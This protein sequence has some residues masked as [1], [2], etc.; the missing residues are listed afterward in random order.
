MTRR[1]RRVFTA[2]HMRTD[3]VMS[4]LTMVFGNRFPNK[5]LMQHSDRG[6]QYASFRYQEALERHGVTCSMI[7]RGDCCGNAV[8]E[9]FFGTLKTELIH[10]QTWP[11]RASARVAVHDYLELLYSRKRMHSTLGHR[12][13]AEFEADYDPA[14]TAA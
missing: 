3:L 9:S 2:E 13:P 4:A 10:R 8:M 12:T 5:E 11:T 1:A 7:R 14:A 6:S